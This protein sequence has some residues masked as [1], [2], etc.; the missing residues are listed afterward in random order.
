MREE[1]GEGGGVHA[2]AQYAKGLRPR[3]CGCGIRGM[4]SARDI[5]RLWEPAQ[6]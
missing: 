1:E 3:L 5:H 4:R 2:G 6:A